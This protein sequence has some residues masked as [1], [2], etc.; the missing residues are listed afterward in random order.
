MGRQGPSEHVRV[1]VAQARS[2][3]EAEIQRRPDANRI[4]I[5][6]DAARIAAGRAAMLGPHPNTAK[7]NLAACLRRAAPWRQAAAH[8]AEIART[9]QW[10]A[11][12][13]RRTDE[14]H[15]RSESPI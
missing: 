4:D 7:R 1:L 13:R 14:R 11:V 6:R 12:K 15:Q 5:R 9:M 10:N 2:L 3:R 8:H